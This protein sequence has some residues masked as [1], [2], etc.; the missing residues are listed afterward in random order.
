MRRFGADESFDEPERE[1]QAA[2]DASGGNDVAVIN[3][4]RADY[5]RAG[6]GQFVQRSVIR[7]RGAILQQARRGQQHRAG[8]DGSHHHAVAKQLS[9]FC[10]Q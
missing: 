3:H 2:S 4:A 1:V 8:A 7:G 10:R 6:G 5:S 9:E